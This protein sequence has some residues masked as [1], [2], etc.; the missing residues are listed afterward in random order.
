[1]NSQAGVCEINLRC[2]LL[3]WPIAGR[4]SQ[5]RV[6]FSR[7]A[8]SSRTVNVTP[9]PDAAEDWQPRSKGANP[10]PAKTAKRPTIKRV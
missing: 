6:I 2:P 9:L 3:A 8:V 10:V 4:E 1:M 5:L 7:A